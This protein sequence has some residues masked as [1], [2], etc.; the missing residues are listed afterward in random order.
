MDALRTLRKMVFEESD[1]DM[2][3]AMPLPPDRPVSRDRAFHQWESQAR[4][5][6][7]MAQPLPA[8]R[9]C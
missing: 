2:L 7:P 9:T 3:V 1:T 4:R 5:V 6:L 8:T